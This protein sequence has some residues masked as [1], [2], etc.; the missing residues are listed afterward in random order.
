MPCGGKTSFV[1]GDGV[2]LSP[3]SI[4]F[5]QHTKQKSATPRLDGVLRIVFVIYDITFL[6]IVFLFLARRI[7]YFYRIKLHVLCC[8]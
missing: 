6:P 4:S 7:L 8:Q 1:S 2:C 3:T 5:Y